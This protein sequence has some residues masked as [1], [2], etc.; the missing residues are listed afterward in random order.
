MVVAEAVLFSSVPLEN[1]L[2]QNSGFS[3]IYFS[4]FRC[5]N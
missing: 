3:D 5:A 2:L 1:K 4:D